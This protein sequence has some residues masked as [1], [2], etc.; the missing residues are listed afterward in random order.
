MFAIG[1][2]W[3]SPLEDT[4]MVCILCC[5]HLTVIFLQSLSGT[6]CKTFLALCWAQTFSRKSFPNQGTAQGELRVEMNEIII[7]PPCWWKITLFHQ[8]QDWFI[9]QDW[10]VLL[11]TWLAVSR[12]GLVWSLTL[13]QCIP[14][15][16]GLCNQT[17]DPLF[18]CQENDS[19]LIW[20]YLAHI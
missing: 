5:S 19:P 15:A 14:C 10:T 11:L 7:A 8:Q 9:S 18:P 6:L 4:L 17:A 20:H 16:G 3:A 13:S 2:L 12:K 1:R